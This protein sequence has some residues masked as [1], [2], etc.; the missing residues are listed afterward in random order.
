MTLYAQYLLERE[1]IKIIESEKGF[2]TYV[3]ADGALYIVDVFIEPSARRTGEATAL[4]A[5]V[6]EVAKSLGFNKLMGSVALNVNGVTT[7]L[8]MMLG[9]GYEFLSLN[10][11]KQIMYFT[12]EI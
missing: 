9:S 7:S 1:G 4:E 5:R 10:A 3:P 11:E 12:K 2:M 6:I 8:K